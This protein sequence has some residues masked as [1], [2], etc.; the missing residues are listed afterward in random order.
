MRQVDAALKSYLLS[1]MVASLLKHDGRGWG[2]GLASTKLTL[3]VELTHD[4]SE[5]MGSSP[6]LFGL[7][8]KMLCVCERI[9]KSAW[10]VIPVSHPTAWKKRLHREIDLSVDLVTSC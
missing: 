1:L 7:G 2:K 4:R 3:V 8:A 10:I 6:D 9:G 5:W